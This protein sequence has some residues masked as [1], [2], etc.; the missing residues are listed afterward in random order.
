MKIQFSLFEGDLVNRLFSSIGTGTR[1]PRHLIARSLML[2]GLTWVPLAVLA[3]IGDVGKGPGGANF[4]KD[5]AAYMQFLLGLP[6]FVIAERIVSVHTRDA[7][8]QFVSTGV[9]RYQDALRLDE[10]HRKAERWRRSVLPDLVCVYI[11]YF[12]SFMTLMPMLDDGTNTWH[13]YVS[14]PGIHEGIS[15]A[16]WWEFFIAL[17]LL[18]YWWLRW[19]WK[20]A[21]WSWYLFRISRFH[22]RLIASH[23]DRT[24]GIGF[25]SDVQSR[26]GLAILAYGVTNVAATVAYKVAFEGATL[27]LQSVWGPLVGFVIGAPLLFTLPLFM[28][29]KQLPRT[30]K[31]ALDRYHRKAVGYAIAFERKWLHA[32]SGGQDE[33][34]GEARLVGLNTLNAVYDHVYRMRVVPFDARSFLELTAQTL[35]SLV[36]LLPYLGVSEPNLKLMEGVF[37]VMGR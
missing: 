7:A 11:A 35:G 2:V 29:T 12:L 19:I 21:L 5:V 24:G 31:R 14:N 20:I 13:A 3:L 33:A 27:A 36:P 37:K 1:R 9:I 30:K 32:P 26:F 15:A 18:N 17:P 25:L 4:F 22:L 10:F 23:P 34:L 8:I 16:G 28:F 6:L